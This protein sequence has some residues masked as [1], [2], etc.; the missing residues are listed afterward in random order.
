M[1]NF[2]LK[3]FIKHIDGHIYQLQN[4]ARRNFVTNLAK[5]RQLRTQNQVI[6]K[7]NGESRKDVI[8]SNK[9]QKI[10]LSP[11]FHK[12]CNNFSES[13]WSVS[14]ASISSLNGA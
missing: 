14:S 6:E 5:L 2:T 10:S 3:I 11:F 13:T 1:V 7:K 8:F 4:Q 9:S 12:K